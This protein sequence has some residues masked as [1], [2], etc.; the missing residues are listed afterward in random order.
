MIARNHSP[1]TEFTTKSD[2]SR[3]LSPHVYLVGICGSGMKALAEVFLGQGWRVSGADLHAVSPAGTILQQAGAQ[4]FTQHATQQVAEDVTLLVYSPAVSEDNPERRIARLRGIPQFA[5][6]QQLGRMM[7]GKT[8]I[9]IAGTHGKS[10]TTALTGWILSQAQFNPTVVVGAQQ[11]NGVSNGWSGNGP[12]FVAESCEYRRHFLALRPKYAVILGVESDHFDCFHGTQETIAAFH[13]FA[14]RVPPNGLILYRGDCNGARAACRDALA[15]SETFSLER[16]STWTAAEIS[17]TQE[18]YFAKVEYQGDYFCDLEL[19]IPGRHHLNNAL[20]SAALCFHQGVS[21]EAISDAT[22]KFRGIRRRFEVL[23]DWCG[24]RV[25]DD[26]A[27]HPTAIRATIET[28][29]EYF[30]GHRL[31]C[32]FQPHQISRTLGLWEEFAESFENVD[33][34]TIV[35]VFGA[36]ESFQFELR[37]VSQKLAEVISAKGVRATFQDS[38]DQTRASLD[39]TLRPGDVL[40]TLGAGDIDRI[41]YARTD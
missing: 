37:E 33:Q 36:R 17:R 6:H 39:D 35:P 34:V 12:H 10:T 27:H 26:Y 32:V 28:A 20:A 15:R 16:G 14:N 41:H 23:R 13:E 31:H 11:V 18:G 8:G 24:A 2:G 1:L 5:Y 21:P 40:L 19:R 22:K 9:S 4:I 7:E 38:L 30:P 3:I 29:R 25:I